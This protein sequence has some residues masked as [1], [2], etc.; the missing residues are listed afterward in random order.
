MVLDPLQVKDYV[1]SV[2]CFDT[3]HEGH[4]KLFERMRLY[5]KQVI[6]G[7]HDDESILILKN[8]LPLDKLQVRIQVLI[9]TYKIVLL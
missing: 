2:G 9:Q 6:V 3:F 8:H 5:G 1:F 7:I 4:V